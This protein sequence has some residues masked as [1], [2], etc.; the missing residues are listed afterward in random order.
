MAPTT[1]VC[2]TETITKLAF[3]VVVA[4][5]IQASKHVII[6]FINRRAEL[7]DLFAPRTVEERLIDA[8]RVNA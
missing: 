1:V 2:L 8:E 3:Y 5:G 4:Y 6:S 7:N